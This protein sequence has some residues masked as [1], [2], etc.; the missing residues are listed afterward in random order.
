M[1]FISIKCSCTLNNYAHI[2]THTHC[3]EIQIN[4]IDDLIKTFSFNV[5]WNDD[6]EIRKVIFNISENSFRKLKIVYL[7]NLI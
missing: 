6:D 4:L 3:F 5:M 1:L 2:H 7:D